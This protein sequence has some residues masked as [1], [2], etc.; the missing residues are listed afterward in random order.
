[1][2]SFVTNH[3]ISGDL[4][5]VLI[6]PGFSAG[7][8]KSISIANTHASDDVLVDLYIHTL[9]LAGEA[10]TSYYILKGKLIQKGGTL[11]LNSDNIRFD[12]LEKTGDGMYIK[13]NASTST[14][15]VIISK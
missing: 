11:V 13:L 3:N 2:A 15:D 7:N 9:S 1:M 4:A 14:A 5:T 10:A 6:T 12:N 8:I